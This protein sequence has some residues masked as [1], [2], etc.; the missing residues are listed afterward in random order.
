MAGISFGNLLTLPRTGKFGPDPINP[1]IGLVSGLPFVITVLVV[2]SPQLLLSLCY[3]TF[4]KLFT[5]IHMGEEWAA[6][7]EKHIP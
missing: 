3:I 4:K 5:R 1:I 2:N 7:S 6:F